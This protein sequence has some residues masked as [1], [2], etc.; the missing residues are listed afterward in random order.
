[1]SANSNNRSHH[2]FI[3]MPPTPPP[4]PARVATAAGGIAPANTLAAESSPITA[5]SSVQASKSGPA[6]TPAAVQTPRAFSRTPAS[7]SFA[8]KGPLGAPLSTPF[9]VLQTDSIESP[10]DTRQL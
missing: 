4:P 9:S 7:R 1:M 3:R 8:K 5:T 10:A 2:H 6:A